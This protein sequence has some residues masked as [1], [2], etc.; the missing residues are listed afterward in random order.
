MA[1]QSGPW[2]DERSVGIVP[3]PEVQPGGE[4]AG[5]KKKESASQ[6]D[7]GAKSSGKAKGGSE[8]KKGIAVS[9]C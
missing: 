7:E 3:E 8:G 9:C 4:N 5:S 2:F 1:L 6:A